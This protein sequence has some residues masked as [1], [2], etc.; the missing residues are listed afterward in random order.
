MSIPSDGSTEHTLQRMDIWSGN[1]SIENEARA[2]GLQ[3]FVYS[4]P[5]RGESRGGDVHY[6]SLCA[7]GV[8]TRL[9][10]ADV[11]GHGESV[12]ETSRTLRS[13]MRRFINAKRQE[14]LI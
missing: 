14:R 2:P 12:S 9:I 8:L 10:L 3:I 4:Q 5:Y 1:R 7:G 6:V 11:S 13:Q